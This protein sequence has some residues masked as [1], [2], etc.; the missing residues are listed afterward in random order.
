VMISPL[1]TCCASLARIHFT[2]MRTAAPGA[3][4][5]YRGQPNR[6]FVASRTLL[7][8]GRLIGSFATR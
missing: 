3:S 8:Y 5:T 1:A 6:R 2:Y 7:L 4:R